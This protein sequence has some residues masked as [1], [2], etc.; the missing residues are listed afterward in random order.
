MQNAEFSN[1]QETAKSISQSTIAYYSNRTLNLIGTYL[2]YALGVFVLLTIF[3]S[4]KVFPFHLLSKI[5]GSEDV[6]HA[7]GSKSEAQAFV[8][9]VKALLGLCG[10]LLIMM[11][12]NISRVAGKNK[13]L[14]TTADSLN[15]YITT[16]QKLQ[17]T[18]AGMST[19]DHTLV[20]KEAKSIELKP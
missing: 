14:R 10:I 19:S 7:I 13:L 16:E 15:K 5:N 20:A 17:S 3:I 1:L 4:D 2:L 18:L 8:F 12:N 9:A 6:I 11:G